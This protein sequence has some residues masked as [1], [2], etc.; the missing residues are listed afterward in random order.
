[1][2]GDISDDGGDADEG[3]SDG[4]DN[5]NYS[6]DGGDADEGCSDGDEDDGDY[7]DDGEGGDYDD[8]D[9][10]IYKNGNCIVMGMAIMVIGNMRS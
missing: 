2:C 3:C 5:G 1:M 7:D 6:D 4:D 8:D 10:D 9:K